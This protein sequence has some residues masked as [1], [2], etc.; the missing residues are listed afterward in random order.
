M[1]LKSFCSV[2]EQEVWVLSLPVST[3]Q[4]NSV[5]YKGVFIFY[6]TVKIVWKATL[7]KMF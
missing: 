2:N 6:G 3:I 4:I 1:P 5:K 7:P